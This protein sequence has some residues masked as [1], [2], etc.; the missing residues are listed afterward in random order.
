MWAVQIGR[1]E[2][3]ADA[4][5]LTGVRTPCLDGHMTTSITDILKAR[6]AKQGTATLLGALY[7]LEMRTDLSL[8]ES[9]TKAA[10]SDAIT[11]RHDLDAMMDEVFMDLDFAGTYTDAIEICLAR[12]EV[13]L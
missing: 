9:L 12:A 10:I 13:A 4:K 1:E 5:P 6:A 11:E 7:I 3:E 8:E 2:R